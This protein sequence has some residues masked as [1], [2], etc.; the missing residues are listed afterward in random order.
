MKDKKIRLCCG[1][2]G[3]PTIEKSGKNVIITDDNGNVV[4]MKIKEAELI[5]SAL[6]EL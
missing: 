2:K 4:V 5:R 1:G 6:K 3:C